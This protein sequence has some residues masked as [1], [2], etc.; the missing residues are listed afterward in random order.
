MTLIGDWKKR[1]EYKT[2]Q[3]KHKP[4]LVRSLKDWPTPMVVIWC[5]D[6]RGGHFYPCPGVPIFYGTQSFGMMV[7]D[8]FDE[9]MD[10]PE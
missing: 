9:W 10:I 4:I 2:L 1:E 3:Y 8:H 7:H 5:D 6:Y